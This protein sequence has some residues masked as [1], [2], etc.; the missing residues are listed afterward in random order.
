MTWLAASD[1]QALLSLYA[2]VAPPTVTAPGQGDLATS[3]QRAAEL[4]DP[5]P[6]VWARWRNGAGGVLL[7]PPATEVRYETPGPGLIAASYHLLLG[8]GPMSPIEVRDVFSG[9]IRTG[10][11]NQS[12][13]RRAGA[14]LPGNY[15]TDIS[16]PEIAQLS[17]YCGSV[18]TYPGLSTLSY[19]IQTAATDDSFKRQVNIFI[20]GGVNVTRLADGV[21][22]PSDNFADLI[23]YLMQ[24]SSTIPADMIDISALTAT[25]IFLE[26]Q[27][28]TCN[29]VTN[30]RTS[31][32]DLIASWG[33]YFLVTESR[34]GGQLGLRPIVPTDAQGNILTGPLN[35]A[36][37]FTTDNVKPES[38]DIN[39][40]SLGDR[41]PFTIQARWR[42]QPSNDLGITRVLETRYAGTAETGPFELQDLSQF[43]TSELHA[44]R[45][46]AHQLARRCHLSHTARLRA[47]PGAHST[48]LAPGAVVRVTLP[49]E[50]SSGGIDNWDYLYQVERIT[51]A[52]GGEVGYELTHLP[53]DAL[54]RSL[55]ALD[56]I[57]A[58]GTGILLSPQRSGLL[59]DTNSS[60]DATVPPDIGIDPNDPATEA[61]R[62]GGATQEQPNT[63]GD[64]AAP[65]GEEDGPGEPQA[66]AIRS[67]DSS[68]TPA[69]IE[70]IT[71]DTGQEAQYV[72]WYFRPTPNSDYKP[73]TSYARKALPILP[74]QPSGSQPL[75][76]NIIT[77]NSQYYAKYYCPEAGET[78]PEQI[79]VLKNERYTRPYTVKPE[80]L[81][82]YSPLNNDTI[83]VSGS[84]SVAFAVSWLKND[85]TYVP[86]AWV[87]YHQL[88]HD[89][90]T[91]FIATY[92]NQPFNYSNP[93]DPIHATRLWPLAQDPGLVGYDITA[94]WIGPTAAL[95]SG[96]MALV[97]PGWIKYKWDANGK[98]VQVP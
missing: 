97:P 13:N 81:A 78:T 1:P 49:R 90:G 18:G 39:Y 3:D 43:A 38:L 89:P 47:R 72:E 57:A 37:R 61:A 6:V 34:N 98:I 65:T 80:D 93:A 68:T 30:E 70:P 83:A 64:E 60:T 31:L 54:R 4:G 67:Q 14:W 10:S 48:T 91:G 45:F 58:V 22:G 33:P 94:F 23:L 92:N 95:P 96:S 56:V 86:A 51:R 44:A 76:Q 19:Q 71:C 35:Y 40:T 75:A 29:C 63:L 59:Q 15:V 9:A 17:Q 55:V 26:R 12:Y 46:S 53:V 16:V 21:Y 74:I 7:S 62:A 79:K 25:A 52:H 87:A 82:P 24:R 88:L 32:A 73:Y 85:G 66:D 5:I 41:Q 2:G 28:F 84:N 50:A 27:G 20:R 11:F 8:E 36:Y 69:S 42:Q 77:P